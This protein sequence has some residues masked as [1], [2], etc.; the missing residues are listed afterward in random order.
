MPY[1]A[2][3]DIR[4]YYEEEGQGEPLLLL[5]GGLGAADP[6]VS[7]SWAA[8]RPALAARYHTLAL[9]HRGHGRT[10][11]PAGRLSYAQLAEDIAAFIERL[12]L[13]PVHLAGFSLGG[14]VGLV[15]GVTRPMLLCSLVCVGTNYRVDEPTRE[16]LALFDADALERDEP[17]FAAEL[18][19][20]HDGHH[21]PGYWRELTRQVRAMAEAGLG[22]VED[23]LRHVSVPT[24][25]VTSEADPFNGLE[26]ALAMRRCIPRSELLV[27][28]HAGLDG[29]ANHRVQ[30][31]R[32]AVVS[33]VILDFLERHA[34]AAA[35]VTAG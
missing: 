35:P 30:H 31:T 13:A 29:M 6:A 12:E 4:M 24:L 27:L 20:R 18:A 32:A 22:L 21:H 15:L 1:A 16:A 33:P 11:N 9:E 17:E 5:H 23:D 28:N 3:N 34:G 26:Q 10:D 8:L 19:R 25:L 7:S 2:V 14:E